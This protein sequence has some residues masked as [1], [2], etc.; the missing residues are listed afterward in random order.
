MGHAV[1]LLRGRVTDNALK[2]FSLRYC[3]GDDNEPAHRI[4]VIDRLLVLCR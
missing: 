4:L 1:C 3:G 2:L